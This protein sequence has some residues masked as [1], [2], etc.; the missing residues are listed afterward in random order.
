MA[1]ASGNNNPSNVDILETVE[2]IQVR[3]E[4]VLDR[5]EHFKNAANIRRDKLLQSK[6]YAFFKFD[7]DDLESWIHEKLR[8][9]NED[10]SNDVTNIQTKLT[11]HE[12]ILKTSFFY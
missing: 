1:S 8:I 6:A 3:R 10:V 11:R 9:A 12:V 5:Y 7:A 4:Q 2:D